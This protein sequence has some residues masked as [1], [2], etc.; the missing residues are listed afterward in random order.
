MEA[1]GLT[2]GRKLLIAVLQR[3]TETDVAARCCV[4]QSNVSRWANGTQTPSTEAR[5]ALEANYK[6]PATSWDLQSVSRLGDV[7]HAR[8]Y[9]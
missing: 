7:V 9:T 6:I 3:T 1:A 8:K 5:C 4:H 2:R